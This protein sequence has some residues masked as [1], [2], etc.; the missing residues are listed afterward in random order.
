MAND[1]LLKFQIS[2]T[3]TMYL[4]CINQLTII[5]IAILIEI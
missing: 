5:N 1:K 4:H 3:Q 2:K